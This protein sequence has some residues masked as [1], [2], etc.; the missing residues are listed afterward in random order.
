M[1][2]R[3]HTLNSSLLLNR[4]KSF[5]EVQF[6]DCSLPEMDSLILL[7]RARTEN[8][9]RK[10]NGLRIYIEHKSKLIFD[11]KVKIV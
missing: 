9:R 10:P 5:S 3:F 7:S 1:N 6:D 2:V 4:S 11:L 8:R